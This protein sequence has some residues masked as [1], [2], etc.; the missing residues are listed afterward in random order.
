[1]GGNLGGRR[2]TSPAKED[3][4]A[5][6]LGPEP[7]PLQGLNPCPSRYLQR[8]CGFQVKLLCLHAMEFQKSEYDIL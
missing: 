7:K 6:S 2:F 5:G 1:M 8:W 3:A 4:E